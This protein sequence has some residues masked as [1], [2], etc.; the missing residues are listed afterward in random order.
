M[1]LLSRFGLIA[2]IIAAVL[3]SLGAS[4]LTYSIA[5]K[6][7]AISWPASAFPIGYTIDRRFADAFGTATVEKAFDAWAAVPA[8]SISFKPAAVRDGIRAAQ[9]GVNTLSMADGLFANQGFIAVTT[10][11]HDASGN[12]SEADIQLDPSAGSGPYG[13]QAT[14]EHEVGHFLGLDH[15]AV[16][17]SVM[18]PYVSRTSSTDL[19]S[20]DTT[21]IAALYPKLGPTFAGATIKGK[22]VGNDGGIFAAQVVALNDNG[23]PVATVLTNAG[24]EFVLQ[25]VPDGVYRIY[26]EPLDGPVG[27]RN[28]DGIYRDAKVTSFPTT[29]ATSSV[30]RVASGNVYG[31]LVVNSSG[32]PVQLNP[33]WIGTAATGS[34][35]FTLNAATVDVRPGQS[36]SLA[37]GGDGFTSGMTT[38]EVMNPSVKRISDFRYAANFAFAS[39]HVS[40][41]ASNASAVLLVTS[42]NQS[43]TLTG[44]LRIV[45]S[46]GARTRVARK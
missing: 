37:V 32:A 36:F 3:P 21:A 25:G 5:G 1:L 44:G 11:W 41:A 27:P 12:I 42:G 43:A 26:A 8:A 4:P 17:S 18:Y 46:T 28:L 39:F 13:V 15:S 20:D 29:F 16:L 22:V 31:N 35:D 33:L 14:I 23:E 45:G 34:S 40:D 10:N 24:G 2:A 38:F 30:I 9:D 19:D 7:K 6:P